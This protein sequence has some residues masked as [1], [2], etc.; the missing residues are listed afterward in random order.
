MHP[1]WDLVPAS[2]SQLAVQRLFSKT[3]FNSDVSHPIR[4]KHITNYIQNQKNISSH[5][6][7]KKP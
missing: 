2:Q 4:K 3:G 7:F 6:G 1:V 5:P